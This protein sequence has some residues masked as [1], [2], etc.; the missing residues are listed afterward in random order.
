MFVCLF[1]NPE[2]V[3]MLCWICWTRPALITRFSEI[4]FWVRKIDKWD[5]T[6]QA[7][8]QNFLE[9]SFWLRSRSLLTRKQEYTWRRLLLFVTLPMKKMIRI[10]QASFFGEVWC[11]SGWWGASL[12]REPGRGFWCIHAFGRLQVSYMWKDAC[13]CS[14]PTWLVK[15]WVTG[16]R[17]V[18]LT[19]GGCFR[20]FQVFNFFVVGCSQCAVFVNLSRL[21]FWAFPSAPLFCFLFRRDFV[22]VKQEYEAPIGSRCKQQE[23]HPHKKP[24]GSLWRIKICSFA[25]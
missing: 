5:Q 2:C 11:R 6:F 20:C 19:D 13:K 15:S 3:T 8:L 16:S 21:F 7:G 17:C 1:Q 10:H 18:F 4:M 14:D 22:S 9:K 23:H 12:P 25:K 24:V